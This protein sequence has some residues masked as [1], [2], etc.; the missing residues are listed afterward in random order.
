MHFLAI[1]SLLVALYHDAATL[2]PQ[3]SEAP[4]AL[5]CTQ[6]I[7]APLSGDGSRLENFSR[8]PAFA[9]SD[10]RKS[11]SKLHASTWQGSCAMNGALE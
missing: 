6:I 3:F 7:A 11:G 2:R 4:G 10:V 1:S 5:H 8:L 9:S